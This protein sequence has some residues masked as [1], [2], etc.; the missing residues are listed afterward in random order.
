MMTDHIANFKGQVLPEF[1]E[2]IK[3]L[4]G[5]TEW[6]LCY[7]SAAV[8]MEHLQ[9]RHD[10]PSLKYKILASSQGMQEVYAQ[11][12]SCCLCGKKIRIDDDVRFQPDGWVVHERCEVRE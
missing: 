5:G 11:T 7:G 3:S 6:I 12:D 8:A 9:L 1:W 4:Q 10:S 2:L